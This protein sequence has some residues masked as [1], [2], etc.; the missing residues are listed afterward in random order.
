MADTL[1]WL[2][3]IRPGMKIVVWAHNSHLGDAR[4]TEISAHGEVNLGQLARE[5]FPKEVFSIGFS[6]HSGEVTAASEWDAPAERKR[7]RPALEGSYEALFHQTRIPAFLLLLGDTYVRE[8]LRGPM[9]ER[10]IGVVYLPQSERLSHYFECRLPDQFDAVIHIDRTEALI[11]FERS[12]W[13]ASEVPETYPRGVMHPLC[14]NN[15]VQHLR[16]NTGFAEIYARQRSICRLDVQPS[17]NALA[18]LPECDAGRSCHR[19]CIMLF[20]IVTDVNI[21][22]LRVAGSIQTDFLK[23]SVLGQ[24]R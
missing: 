1:A 14:R 4:A 19:F 12:A 2:R 20:W 23:P 21:Y 7:V 10:A 18:C 15:P 24:N 5:R 9:L 17:M 8:A 11:P 13:E 16:T 22:T 3:T 6:T